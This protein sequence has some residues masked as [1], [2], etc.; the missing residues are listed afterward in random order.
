MRRFEIYYA[1]GQIIS[2][3]TRADWIITPGAD[4]QG[5]VVLH[6]DDS[7]QERLY[8]VDFYI[9]DDDNQIIGTHILLRGI[10]K[11]G[12][13]VARPVFEAIR[14]SVFDHSR[15]WDRKSDTVWVPGVRQGISPP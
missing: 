14:D 2:G 4:V 13:A 11:H 1:N 12:S 3:D 8:G 10:V 15:I 9:L 5:V 6:D 7:M